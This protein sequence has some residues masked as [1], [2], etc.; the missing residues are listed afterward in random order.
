MRVAYA[1]GLAG[2]L[3]DMSEKSAKLHA[4]RASGFRPV[5]DIPVT[6]IPPGSGKGAPY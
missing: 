6:S 2:R 1:P 3:T 4:K 5:L